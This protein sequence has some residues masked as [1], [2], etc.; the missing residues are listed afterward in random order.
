MFQERNDRKSKGEGDNVGTRGWVGGE[1]TSLPGAVMRDGSYHGLGK[2]LKTK[3]GYK[4]PEALPF[5]RFIT[6]IN[7]N[8]VNSSNGVV[9]PEPNQC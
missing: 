8:G 5:V 3:C 6:K 2:F 1:V 9:T 4:Y 7:M